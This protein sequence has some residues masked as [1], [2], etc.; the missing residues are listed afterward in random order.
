[1]V[2]LQKRKLY[3]KNRGEW[4]GNLSK[5]IIDYISY[6]DGKNNLEH[7]AKILKINKL[8]IKKITNLLKLQI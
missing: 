5:N 4:I 6:S 3:S 8:T 7:I 1:M 2:L